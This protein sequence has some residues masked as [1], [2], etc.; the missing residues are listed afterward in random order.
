MSNALPAQTNP[1]PVLPSEPA[2]PLM[3]KLRAAGAADLDPLGWHYIEVLAGRTREQ[4]GAAH[5]LLQNRLRQAL[6]DFGKRMDTPQSQRSVATSPR[7]ETPSPLTAL[8]KE[9]SA[10]AQTSR[11]RTASHA[12]DRQSDSPQV[13]Q[14]RQKLHHIG[15]QKQVRQALAQAPQNAGPIN[16]HMLVLRALGLMR[17]ISP[18]YLHRFMGYVDT[19]LCLDEAGKAG[20]LAKKSLRLSK[21]KR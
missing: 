9:I 2:E 8:L 16:S 6:T 13:Q 11:D 10:C 7:S 17:D 3:E 19:L 14:L 5:A 21:T 12:L 15:V 18:D 1:M 4:S 20:P